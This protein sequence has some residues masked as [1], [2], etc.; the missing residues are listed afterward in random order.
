MP[1][2]ANEIRTRDG[3]REIV[4]VAITS[5]LPN[6]LPPRIDWPPLLGSITPELLA[7]QRALALL[8]G[9]ARG[10]VDSRFLMGP[11]W[12][13]EA[14]L[15]SLIEDTVT[16]PEA[17]A[18]AEARQSADEDDTREVVNYLRALQHG[19][20][21]ELP[22]SLR[23]LRE[24]HERLLDGV[25]GGRDRPG[26]FRTE[27]NYI[28]NQSLG[29]QAARFVPPPPG[30]H[31]Q[32]C[33]GAFERFLNDTEGE[34]PALVRISLAHYQFECIHPF[35][36]GNGRL[37]RLLIMLSLCREGLLSQPWIYI[38]GHIEQNQDSY[39]DLLLRVST[40]GDWKAWLKFML[41]G[42]ARS[43]EDATASVE[44]LLVLRDELREKVTGPRSSA[45]LL[46]MIDR[47]FEKPVINVKQACELLSISHTAVRRHLS[48]LERLGI[49][50]QLEAGGREQFWIAREI[51][52]ASEASES[53]T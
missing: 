46:R 48:R 28:G 50:H 10:V 53:G 47:L 40:H 27:Q 35:R 44:R 17:L 29:V 42:L 14:R 4:R 30:Q 41:S 32:E 18:L 43:A 3:R 34:L 1:S 8:E 52:Q 24:M 20:A 11:F 21:S 16:T 22:L 6:P 25:R 36:D 19:L 38:S 33:L 51:L 31:L 45:L 15:S 12:R 9:R 37:G 13:R 5:F 49:L 39:R 2:A 26:E 23:L 7:A